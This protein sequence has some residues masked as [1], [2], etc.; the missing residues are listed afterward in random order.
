MSSISSS[1]CLTRI[2]AGDDTSL[3]IA[4][5][6]TVMTRIQT[7]L[8]D[9]PDAQRGYVANTLLNLAVTRMVK[10]EGGTRTASLLMRLGDVIAT[11]SDAPPAARAIDLSRRD[12]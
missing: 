9:I 4:Q 12:A 7:A 5:I 8:R 3:E 6:Q 2:V 11:G 1:R 10:E